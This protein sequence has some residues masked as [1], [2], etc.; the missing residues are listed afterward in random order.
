[1]HNYDFSFIIP[2]YN[3]ERYL[4]KALNS[5]LTQKYDL[6]KIQVILINDGSTDNG[7]EICK[8]YESDNIIVIDKKNEGVSKA[9][10]DGIKKAN[11]RYIAFLD[12]D[13]YLSDNFC[14]EVFDF[15][16]SSYN[17]IDIVT[18]PLI[19][20]T[21]KKVKKH[22]RYSK[23]YSNE[24]RIFDINENPE[25]I[26]T[27]INICVKNKYKNN[28]LFNEN[29][30]LSEDEEFATKNIML[31]EKIGYCNNC[32]YYY[33]K[34]NYHSTTKNY[35]VTDR[36]F[37]AYT[38]YY[39]SLLKKYKNSIYI[40]NLFLNTLR[41]RLDES[42]LIPK[43]SGKKEEYLSIL[44]KLLSYIMI[45]DILNLSF[46]NMETKLSILEL[47]G[48][49]YSLSDDNRFVLIG[50]RKYS[51]NS[52][53]KFVIDKLM[54]DKYPII[55][56]YCNFKYPFGFELHKKNI[57]SESVSNTYIYEFSFKATDSKCIDLSS[58]DSDIK[59]ILK[60]KTFKLKYKVYV[61]NKKIC[62]STMGIRDIIKKVLRSI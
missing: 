49:D 52:P 26:Q 27:T 39:S 25:I 12:S 29:M 18:F 43:D 51:I 22:F 23:L 32:C 60:N 16:E 20:F 15:F 11:G 61:E 42:K 14:Q 53:L 46:L 40:R 1:M 13:D 48:I 55:S 44:K 41:W 34:N 10:N 5:I 62:I 37:K 17:Q 33:R 19:N 3:S 30:T 4:T 38:D 36:E 24:N 8:K 50:R 47:K 31:K 9:R 56:G 28:I 57:F 21:G 45:E 2:V 54:F 35:N 59:I 7:L 6:D 58:V